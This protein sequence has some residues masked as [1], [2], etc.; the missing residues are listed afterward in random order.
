MHKHYDNV[1]RSR[2]NVFILCIF[3][4]FSSGLLFPID[5]SNLPAREMPTAA[6]AAALPLAWEQHRNWKRKKPNGI[7]NVNKPPPQSAPSSIFISFFLVISL[8]CFLSW[9]VCLSMLFLLSRLK[10]CLYDLQLKSSL[11][12][13]LVWVNTLRRVFSF[14][15][16]STFH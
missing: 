15:L 11:N 16:C 6:D 1:F 5:L 8:L 14:P 7:E 13:R 10:S 12:T 4:V 3:P 2:K 9:F